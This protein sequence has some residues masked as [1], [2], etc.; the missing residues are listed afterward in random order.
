MPPEYTPKFVQIQAGS[1]GFGYFL[2]ALD[3]DGGVWR[4]VDPITASAWIGPLSTDNW[5]KMPEERES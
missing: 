5:K 1:T 4:L 3:E 2:F